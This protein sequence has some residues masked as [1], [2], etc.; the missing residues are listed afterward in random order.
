MIVDMDKGILTFFI[1]EKQINSCEFLT[2]GSYFAYIS[3]RNIGDSVTLI[4]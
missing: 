2:S 1:D 3:L 4:Q